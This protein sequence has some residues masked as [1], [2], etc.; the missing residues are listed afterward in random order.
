MN[1][2]ET[3]SWAVD[4]LKK[5]NIEDARLEGE[6][7]LAH[8]LNLKRTDLYTQQH[9]NIETK[10]YRIIESFL[11]RRAEHEPT[12]YIT[13][14]QP[15]MSLGFFMDRSVLIPRAE[16][17]NL[18]EASI[19]LIQKSMVHGL[20]SIVDIG[21]GSGAIAVSLAKYLPNVKVIGIDSSPGAV[22]IAK[23]NAE[24]HSVKDRCQFT[25]GNML[26]PLKEKVDFIVSNPPYIPS[27]DIKNL[28]PEVRD[29]EPGVALDGGPDGLNYIRLLI[30]ESPS[31]LK[32]NGSLLVEFGVDQADKIKQLVK[33]RGNYQEIELVKDY[34]GKPRILR[35]T[36]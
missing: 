2:A 34:S 29:W 12:A 17:E 25:P 13:G 32:Q 26:E 1:L 9:R 8:A 15:F 19:A 3:L 31:H 6:I 33:K 11:E 18:V 30:S 24:Y 5:H 36:L 14:I 10:E 27:A 20:L 21:T 23:R 16:T 7:L 4:Y 35:A 22:K 28:Q